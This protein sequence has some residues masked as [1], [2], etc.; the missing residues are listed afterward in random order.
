MNTSVT[1]FQ[2]VSFPGFYQGVYDL[3]ERLYWYEKEEAEYFGVDN[4]EEDVDYTFYREKLKKDIASAWVKCMESEIYNTLGID[5]TLV[6]VSIYSPMYYNYDNDRV[7]CDVQCR[8]FKSI[9]RKVLSLMDKYKNQLEVVIYEN[10]TSYDGFI[11]FMSNTFNGWREYLAN[12]KNYND[13]KFSLYF[14]YIMT[15][16]LM[17]AKKPYETMAKQADHLTWD[18]IEFTEDYYDL[19]DYI[20]YND[21]FWNRCTRN[22]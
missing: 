10:H 5:L 21:E 22:V 14:S 15:Y 4:I 20:T 19:C 3:G 11:S 2:I 16:L 6:N 13:D 12:P 7:Y 9:M 17:I 8:D 18:F 1:N